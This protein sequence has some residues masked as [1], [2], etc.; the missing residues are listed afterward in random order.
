MDAGTQ[1]L[2]EPWRD[3]CVFDTQ[4]NY[5]LDDD[6][7]STN[8]Y[9]D[10]VDWSHNMIGEYPSQYDEWTA[11]TPDQLISR[12]TGPDGFKINKE[13]L[14]DGEAAYNE[15]LGFE[16]LEGPQRT[17]WI[18]DLRSFV[19]QKNA[20]FCVILEETQDDWY[21]KLQ[22][23]Q[24]EAKWKRVA[25]EAILL[26]KQIRE[27]KAAEKD[28]RVGQLPLFRKE[29]W[30]V[31]ETTRQWKVR[32]GDILKFHEKH[33][34]STT[35]IDYLAEDHRKHFH[36]TDIEKHVVLKIHS[37]K[38]GVSISSES[39]YAGEEEVLFPIGTRFEVSK[40]QFDARRSTGS[41]RSVRGDN[42]YLILEVKEV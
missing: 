5:A 15:F 20:Q 28:R 3:L 27:R 14:E 9:Q 30:L 13:L 26:R 11:L 36:S 17:A 33:F 19:E 18:K 38:K 40:I 2:W 34:I 35:R 32:E 4:I 39:V 10:Y 6:P 42:L 31:N 29:K 22:K 8:T 23:I 21:A 25:I 16:T 1:A 7:H 37:R 41:Q 12:Y 24:Q